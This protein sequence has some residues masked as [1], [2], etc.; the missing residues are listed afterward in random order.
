MEAVA[1]TEALHGRD[2]PPVGAHRQHETGPDGVAVHDDGA[3]TA[4]AVLAPDVR[5]GEAERDAEDVDQEPA[6]LDGELVRDVVDGEANRHSGRHAQLLPARS[7]ANA[8]ASRATCRASR[9]RKA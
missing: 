7:A 2:P 9:R 8:I 6:W 1:G 5:A 4:H 3:G